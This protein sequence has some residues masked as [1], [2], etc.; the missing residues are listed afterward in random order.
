VRAF[1]CKGY[2]ATIGRSVHDDPHI[3]HGAG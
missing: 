1:V 3:K 2:G